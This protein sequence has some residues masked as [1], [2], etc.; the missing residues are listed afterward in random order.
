MFVGALIL[1]NP[2]EIVY[3]NRASLLLAFFLHTQSL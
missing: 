2:H 3:I 1:K